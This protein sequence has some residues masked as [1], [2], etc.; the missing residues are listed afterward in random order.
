MGQKEG[1]AVPLSA[2]NW[3]PSNTMWPGPRSTSVPSGILIHPSIQPFG[4]NT[5]TSQTDGQD[6]STGQRS[7][8]I[9][10]TT[11]Q[12]AAQKLVLGIFQGIVTTFYKV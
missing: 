9:G 10:R 2:G 12:A 5:P 8:G 7:D 4:Y 3:F 11:L 1:A 6:R